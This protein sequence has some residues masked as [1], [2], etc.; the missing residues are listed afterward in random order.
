MGNQKSAIKN[1]K[2]AVFVKSKIGDQKSKIGC[3]PEIKNRRSK[4]KNWLSSS[5]Q[6]SA[7]KNQKLAVFLKSKIGD[8]KSKIFISYKY[9]IRRQMLL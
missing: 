5:N 2:L 6:K 8:Q 9:G 1:Q 7:I 3:L 4:I